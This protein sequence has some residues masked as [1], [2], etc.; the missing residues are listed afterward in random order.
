MTGKTMPSVRINP[1]EA[2]ALFKYATIEEM[3]RVKDL[4]DEFKKARELRNAPLWESLDLWDVLSLLSFVYDTGRVQGIRE[5]RGKGT[6][7]PNFCQNRRE[8]EPTT[9]NSDCK[10]INQMHWSFL[11]DVDDLSFRQECAL[12][13]L[14][15]V[16]TI[17][18]E[19]EGANWKMHCNAVFSAYLQLRNLHEELTSCVDQTIAE[20]RKIKGM[21]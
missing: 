1:E 2:I 9:T 17:M 7:K 5:E 21:G 11:N 19:A 13:N 15:S 12:D 14:V 18:E 4:F 16:H 3:H 10:A 6:E 20:R 8:A